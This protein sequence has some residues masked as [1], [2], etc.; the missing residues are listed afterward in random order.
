MR[1]RDRCFV[2]LPNEVFKL[3]YFRSGVETGNAAGGATAFGN[4]PTKKGV[5]IGRFN[6]PLP[7]LFLR[8]IDW[9]GKIAVEIDTS[10]MFRKHLV[11]NT[12]IVVF[13]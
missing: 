2:C 1:Q 4:T 9:P 5:S 13:N 10:E 3:Q 6:F 11:S 7:C 12:F 8:F